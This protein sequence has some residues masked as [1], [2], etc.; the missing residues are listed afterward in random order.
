VVWT[1]EKK[2]T[3]W[4]QSLS[5]FDDEGNEYDGQID[6]G[7]GGFAQSAYQLKDGARDADP[8][9]PTLHLEGV[10]VASSINI[11]ATFIKVRRVAR[12]VLTC[13]RE[14]RIFAGRFLLTPKAKIKD[15]AW[16]FGIH[17][18]RVH[19]IAYAARAKVKARARIEID[20]I[21]PHVVWPNG[22][23]T[24]EWVDSVERENAGA[25]GR[26]LRAT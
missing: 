2:L 19:Q 6:V 22:L 25:S 9:D 18:S 21:N 3:L 15:L 8:A 5:R 10:E 7:S 4:T 16:E 23:N 1:P 13:P 14:R 24:V 26:P 12:R 11:E 17:P 20:G